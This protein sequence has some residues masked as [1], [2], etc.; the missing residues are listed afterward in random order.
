MFLTAHSDRHH[1]KS[2]IAGA[3]YD[4][5][6]QVTLNMPFPWYCLTYA[7]HDAADD[8]LSTTTLLS[9]AE[10]VREF[11]D[12]DQSINVAQVLLISPPQLNQTGDWQMEPLQAVWRGRPSDNS[13][14]VYQYVLQDGRRYSCSQKVVDWA[15]FKDLVQLFAFEH[16]GA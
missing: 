2:R 3:G 15:S 8:G 4:V 12:A 7:R 6:T 5:W 14:F 1:V 11:L 10:Q 16:P 13:F 9:S